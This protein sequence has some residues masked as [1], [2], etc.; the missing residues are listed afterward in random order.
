M[1]YVVFLGHLLIDIEE[2]KLKTQ[3]SHCKVDFIYTFDSGQIRHVR[4]YSGPAQAGPKNLRPD[5]PR[6]VPKIDIR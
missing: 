5:P 1:F 3:G 6:R 2:V 4:E